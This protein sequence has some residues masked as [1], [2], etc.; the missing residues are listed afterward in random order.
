MLKNDSPI[1][2]GGFAK[3]KPL[4]CRGIHFLVGN[5][6]TVAIFW[7]TQLLMTDIPHEA[8]VRHVILSKLAQVKNMVSFTVLFDVW[9]YFT[10]F[11]PLIHDISIFSVQISLLVLS[12]S[13][14]DADLVPGNSLTTS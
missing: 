1:L 12:Y 8:R 3:V 10:K 7:A 6:L 11:K 13:L 4:S 5:F 9:F 14:W 2:Y